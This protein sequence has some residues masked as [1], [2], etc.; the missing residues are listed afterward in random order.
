[1][2]GQA[3]WRMKRSNKAAFLFFGCLIVSPLHAFNSHQPFDISSDVLTYNDET[4]D[5]TAEGHVVVIQTSSTLHA[6]LVRYDRIHKHLVARGHVILREKAGILMGDQMDYDL[7][8]EKGI[9]LGGKG[10][11]SPWFFQ[12]A[13]WEK[14]QDYYIGRDASFTSCDLIDPHYHIR[15]SRVHLIPDKLFWAWNNVFYVDT[16][17][18]FYTPFLYKSL[19]PRSV[20]FQVE[21]GND[22]V[23]GAF[24]KTTTTLRLTDNVYDKFY[25]DRYTTSGTGFGNELDYKDKDYK[26]SLFGYYINPKGNTELEGAPNAPQYDVRAYHWQ[27]LSNALTFQANINHRDNVSFNN[28]FFNQ[29]TN[30]SVTD[31]D[32]SAALTYQKGHNNQLLLVESLEAPDANDPNPLFANTHIQ[33]ASLPEY[34]VTLYQIPLWSPVVSTNTLEQVLHPHH[35]GPLQL[36]ASGSIQD[37]Y[38][39]IDDQTRLRSNASASL[40]QTINLSRNWSFTPSITPSMKWQDKYDPID[41]NAIV[42]STITPVDPSQRYFSRIPGPTGNL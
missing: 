23:K 14:N 9:V 25:L 11:G 4:Q 20:V 19:G 33:T 28:Q 39:R 31:V 42:I 15:S 7:E 5:I 17:P 38:S 36:T 34:D 21:P 3:Y 41:P 10:Y 12:G 6:D 2:S 8:L 24:A 13:T 22:S 18:V 37:F 29:D 16:H 35:L 27:K 40:S 26:G 1:M 32:N 30:Q